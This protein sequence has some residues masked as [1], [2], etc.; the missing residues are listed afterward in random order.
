MSKNVQN[1]QKCRPPLWGGD[2]LYKK[3]VY[4]TKFWAQWAFS[5]DFRQGGHMALPQGK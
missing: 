1:V 4:A 5:R 2:L 3:N